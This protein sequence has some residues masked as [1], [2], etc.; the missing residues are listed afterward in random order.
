MKHGLVYRQHL[1]PCLSLHYH[2]PAQRNGTKSAGLQRQQ[3][4]DAQDV[5][6][7]QQLRFSVSLSLL[8]DCSL[9]A[10]IINQQINLGSDIPWSPVCYIHLPFLP[11]D[12]AIA[13]FLHHLKKQEERNPSLP[14]TQARVFQ[15]LLLV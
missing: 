10:L 1:V 5:R 15:E 9:K 12:Q 2:N 3:P 4:F 7:K 14:C 11:R 13:M 6:V 8:Q